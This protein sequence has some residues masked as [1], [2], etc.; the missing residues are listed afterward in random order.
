MDK[1]SNSPPL[2]E[3]PYVQELFTIMRENGKDT[4]GLAALIGHVSEMEGFV[5]RAEDK[6]S[7]MKSQLSEMKEVQNHPVKTSLQ[8]TIKL[9]EMKV[10]TLKIQLAKLKQNIIEGC[11]KAVTAFK[12]KGITALNSL[13]RF[14]HIR[15]GLSD[16]K[17]DIDFAIQA[18][19]KA[20]AKIE[21][22]SSEY[23]SAG[24]ALKNMVRIAVGKEPLDAKKEAGK[25]AKT[26]AA[27]YMA[28]KSVLTGLKKSINKAISVID[29]M[30]QTESVKQAERVAGKK[31]PRLM[32]RI[33]ANKERSERSK[34]ELPT[35][36]RTKVQGVEV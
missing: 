13:A 25:L 26:I 30:E 2:A 15:D 14:F 16:W 19:C 9:L 12:D 35:P 3:N 22:F 5:K 36:E 8:N 27:P 7:D 17:K 24:R 20:I 28:Q 4:K 18:D 29:K 23:H 33:E 6:I 21:A 32:K 34:L 31:K 1:S 10:A 11:K